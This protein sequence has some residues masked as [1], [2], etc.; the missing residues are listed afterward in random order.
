MYQTKYSSPEVVGLVFVRIILEVGL[1]SYLV[2]VVWVSQCAATCCLRLRR[3]IHL[4]K[5]WEQVT[6]HQRDRLIGC[7][8]FGKV[9]EEE[10][11][12]QQQQQ[13]QQQQ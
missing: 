5:D 3:K 8:R 11:E 1:E 12:Q 13:Q 10:E 7:P 9:E 4:D 2:R 6:E